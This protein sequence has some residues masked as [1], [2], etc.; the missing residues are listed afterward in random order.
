MLMGL[1]SFSAHMRQDV[2]AAKKSSQL[3]HVARGAIYSTRYHRQDDEPH[4]NFELTST[5]PLQQHLHH[6]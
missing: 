1:R 2:L 4:R 5:L 3:S 6:V